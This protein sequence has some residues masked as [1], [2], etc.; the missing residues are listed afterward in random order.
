MEDHMLRPESLV[1][2]EVR[3]PQLYRT[4]KLCDLYAC[5]RTQLGKEIRYLAVIEGVDTPRLYLSET[6]TGA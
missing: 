2:T 5:P 3:R 6:L 4:N 1:P